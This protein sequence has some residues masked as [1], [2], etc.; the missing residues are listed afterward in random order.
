MKEDSNCN[1][2]VSKDEGEYGEVNVTIIGMKDDIYKCKQMIHRAGVSFSGGDD[3]KPE[4]ERCEFE[5]IFI[6]YRKSSLA[7]LLGKTG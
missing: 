7:I 4:K 6:K 2:I 1:I 5:L 3:Y